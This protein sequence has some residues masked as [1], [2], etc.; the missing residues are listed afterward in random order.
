[1]HSPIRTDLVRWIP[2][3]GLILLACGC[4]VRQET[5]VIAY[6]V[7]QHAVIDL[8]KGEDAFADTL[9]KYFGVRKSEGKAVIEY[10]VERDTR[11]KINADVVFQLKRSLASQD[12]SISEI[13]RRRFAMNVMAPY[14]QCMLHD[15]SPTA[16][17]RTAIHKKFAHLFGVTGMNGLSG[18]STSIQSYRSGGSFHVDSLNL[19]NRQILP[20]GL[21]LQLNNRYQQAC[22]L[23][24]TDT[25]LPPRKWKDSTIFVIEAGRRGIPCFLGPEY[26]YSTMKTEYVVVVKDKIRQ[27][28]EEYFQ[29]IDT[30]WLGSFFPDRRFSENLWNSLGLRMT[31]SDA[32][33]IVY[34][35]LKRDF[36]SRSIDEIA[37]SLEF[38]TA[39]HE[40]KHKTDD[41]DLPTM[42][43]NFDCEVSAH[44]T[45][46]ICG[47]T[48]FHA[49]VEAIQRIEGFYANS[50]DERMAAIL[51]QLWD[52][53]AKAK[54]PGFSPESLRQYLSNVYAGYLAKSS[55]TPLPDLDDFRKTLV[56]AIDSGVRRAIARSGK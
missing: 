51:L 21:L 25:I 4:E 36:K 42:T 34:E 13:A 45:Q 37:Q 44:L 41:I 38:E 19:F 33:K 43:I 22:L 53:A 1:M 47:N 18:V 26:G 40:A 15:N 56:P 3:L 28:A 32:D 7:I 49:L 16:D 14:L 50:G 17:D 48:P 5:P 31:R 20:Y 2:L 55:Q 39:I 6:T 24:V 29:Q 54:A 8:T 52:I 27:H 35:L 11:D 46:A 23:N 30:T 10:V 9:V 12:E